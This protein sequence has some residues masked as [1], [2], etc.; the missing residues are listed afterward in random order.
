MNTKVVEIKEYSNKE[1]G[2]LTQAILTELVL[3]FLVISILSSAFMPA[4]YGILTLL[5]FNLAYNNIKIFRKRY[6]TS[7]YV[8]TGLFVLITTIVEYVF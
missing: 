5:M 3:I 8:I 2:L 7:V 6:M 4:L 1:V